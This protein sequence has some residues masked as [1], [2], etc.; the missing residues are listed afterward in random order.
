MGNQDKMST[1][2]RWMSLDIG[3][4][5]VGI[6]LSDP[7]GITAR[8]FSVIPRKP[9][10]FDH[11]QTLVQ[12]YEVRGIVVG[13]PRRTGGEETDLCDQ[14]RQLASEL[15]ERLGIKVRV[16]DERYSTKEAERIMSEQGIPIRERRARRDAF[17]AA[18]IL[19]WFLEE[20]D[21]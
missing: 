21:R 15:E 5:R 20:H 2:G 4:K 17:A 19:Q 18:V 16:F 8:P 12:E 6:A 9:R 11:I 3:T 1:P 10:L 7:L 13:I 14:V